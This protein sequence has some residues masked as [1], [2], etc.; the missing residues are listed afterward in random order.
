[1]LSADAKEAFDE[2]YIL[3]PIS[4]SISISINIILVSIS[5]SITLDRNVTNAVDD[6][7]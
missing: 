3:K 6:I 2:M 7:L 4:I 5:I 1:M